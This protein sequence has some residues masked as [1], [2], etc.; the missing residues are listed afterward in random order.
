MSC[1]KL[2]GGYRQIKKID[3]IKN[4]RE[5]I[6]V[7]V[8]SAALLVVMIFI[9]FLIYGLKRLAELLLTD[10]PEE[11]RDLT[12]KLAATLALCALN[13]ALHETVHG[14]C[15]KIFCGKCRLKIGAKPFYVYVT[16][17]AFFSKRDYNLIAVA[18]I[19]IIGI[20]CAVLCR[21]VPPE[22][23]LAIYTILSINVAGA[24]GDIY[25]F[26]ILSR[27]PKDILI[28]DTGVSIMVYGNVDNL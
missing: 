8:I 25:V 10:N 1:V 2:P 26:S 19:L 6:V 16:S 27:M 28:N 17:N 21:L 24:A 9:G 14:V 18:P 13:A 22:W 3:L 7:N 4:R 5:A 20:S 11:L 12:V 23:F 15:M